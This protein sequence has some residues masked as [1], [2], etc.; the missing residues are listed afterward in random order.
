MTA[1]IGTLLRREDTG[2]SIRQVRKACAAA[3]YGTKK[4]PGLRRGLLFIQQGVA[5]RLTWRVAPPPGAPFPGS[6]GET[7][8]TQSELLALKYEVSLA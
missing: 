7:N 5:Y 1:F 8:L 3:S 2:R 6:P 4:A